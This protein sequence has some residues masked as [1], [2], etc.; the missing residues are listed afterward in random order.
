[1][2]EDGPDPAGSSSGVDTRIRLRAR[3]HGRVQGVWF[4]GSTEALARRRGVDGWVRNRPDGS[5][6][7]IFEGDPAAVHELLEYV[8][9]GPRG[10]RVERV[11]VTEEPSQSE[12]GFRVR[13]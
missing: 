5:V 12:R 1:M 3:V 11:D 2:A 7:A 9:V 10:A 13:S 4:R 8:R 6:E